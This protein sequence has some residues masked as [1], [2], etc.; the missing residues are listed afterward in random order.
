MNNCSASR[1]E[2]CGG[3]LH[4]ISM[5]TGGRPAA[6]A[7]TGILDPLHPDLQQRLNDFPG[8]VCLAKGFL[9]PTRRS[10]P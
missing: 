8:L 6:K 1:L 9:V 5:Q 3:A 2:N 10:T 4:E 7:Y